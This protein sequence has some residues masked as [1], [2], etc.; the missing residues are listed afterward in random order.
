MRRERRPVCVF[1]LPHKEYKRRGTCL[2]KKKSRVLSDI[3]IF[4][5]SKKSRVKADTKRL[6]KI[7]TTLQRS[8]SDATTD[9]SKQWEAVAGRARRKG[10]TSSRR[11]RR[12][13]RQRR[14]MCRRRRREL[15][16]HRRRRRRRRGG[17]KGEARWRDPHLRRPAGKDTTNSN[18]NNNNNRRRRLLLW[19][20]VMT[21]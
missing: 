2:G 4:L 15:A 19:G 18:T 16:P 10:A 21:P 9:N 17:G 12:R 6:Q 1:S 8:T 13:L 11:R 20:S 3:T 7:S 5:P 14:E